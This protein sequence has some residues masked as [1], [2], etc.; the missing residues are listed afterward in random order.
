MNHAPSARRVALVVAL[1]CVLAVLAGA[2][3]WRVSG[4]RWMNVETGSMGTTAPV[5]TLVLTR[6]TTIDHLR[7]GDVVSFRP[8]TRGAPVYTHRIVAISDGVVTTRGDANAINDPFRTTSA[9]L[10]GRVVA[11]LWPVGWLLQ[12]VPWTLLLCAICWLATHRMRPRRRIPVRYAGIW[13]SVS[14]AG[15]IVRPWVRMEQTST[16]VES[17]RVGARVVSTGILP[18]LVTAQKG[19]SVQLN[20]GQSGTVSSAVVDA[21]GRVPLT[22]AA[23]PTGWWLLAIVL[24]CAAPLLYALIVGLKIPAEEPIAEPAASEVDA[25]KGEVEPAASAVDLAEGETEQSGAPAPVV[26]EEER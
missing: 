19:S 16:I 1:A 7:V 13:L 20:A 11:M 6:P 5:G 24:V 21:Q 26:G 2:V 9:Q 12:L 15:L 25:A 4:G 8:P 17:G 18:I 22:A 23:H 14:I 10:V 3:G